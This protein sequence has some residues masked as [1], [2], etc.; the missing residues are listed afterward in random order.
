MNLLSRIAL[1]SLTTNLFL[2]ITSVKLAQSGEKHICSATL[3]NLSD[4][5]YNVF[6][7]SLDSSF[8][9]RCI[10]NRGDFKFAQELVNGYI[11]TNKAKLD[12]YE[13][14]NL[15]FH[16]GQL[17]AIDGRYGDAIKNFSQAIDNEYMTNNTLSWNEYVYGTIY[18]L[19]GNIRKL[20]QEIEK[21]KARNIEID[22]PN[23]QILNNF[24]MCPNDTYKNI[25]SQTSSCLN[26]RP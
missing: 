15:F 21:I 8:S 6:D 7:Q 19:E 4:I 22:A 16:S 18:F 5:T 11:A 23:L 10:A 20:E 3:D 13:I 26:S 2:I 17:A 9:W 24:L 1:V 12:Q 14:Q 25:Y